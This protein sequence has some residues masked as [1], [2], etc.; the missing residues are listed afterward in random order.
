MDYGCGPS[1][2][3]V[4]VIDRCEVYGDDEDY[5]D[6]ECDKDGDVESDGDG[7]VQVDGHVLSFLTLHQLMENE[8]WR[9]VSNNLDLEYLEES[10]LVKYHLAP[11][12]QFENFENFGNAISSDWTPWVNYNIGNS[13][14]EFVIRQVFTSKPALQDAIKLYYIKAYNSM[15][16]LHLQKN[17]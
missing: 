1:S 9:Y 8:Q 5:E 10:S 7:Y 14:G 12:A 11:S 16:L 2:T 6:Q 13:S 17:C 15:W 4:V 3:P